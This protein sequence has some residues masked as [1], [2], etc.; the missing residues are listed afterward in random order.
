MLWGDDVILQ[1][2]IYFFRHGIKKDAK[3]REALFHAT[4]K[5]HRS[6]LVL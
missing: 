1:V 4:R 3:N 5:M 2:F 6:Q